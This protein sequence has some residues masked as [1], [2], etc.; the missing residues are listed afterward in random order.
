M[1][2]VPFHPAGNVAAVQGNTGVN[3]NTRLYFQNADNTIGQGIVQYPPLSSPHISSFS[4]IVPAAE[5]MVGTPIA[6]VMVN[7]TALQEVI[8]LFFHIRQWN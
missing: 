2:A 6:A 3:G 8:Y 4:V 5:A 7:G 1:Q